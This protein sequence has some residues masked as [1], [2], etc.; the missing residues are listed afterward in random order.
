MQQSRRLF[1][2]EQRHHR[3][4][5]II[6]MNTVGETAV[7]SAGT[8]E[9]A[10]DGAVPSGPVDPGWTQYDDAAEQ[11]CGILLGGQQHSGRLT[12]RS[13]NRLLG[14]HR[15]V[16]LPQHT[17]GGDEDHPLRSPGQ[18]RAQPA[19]CVAVSPPVALS[20]RAVSGQRHHYRIGIRQ[21]LC[22]GVGQIQLQHRERQ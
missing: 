4:H 20:I 8:V 17:G 2:L 13:R 7:I 11:L 12:L 9:H 15:A 14:D 6:A 22:T 5:Q 16:V 10:L 18:R 1:R 19:E 3:A 21:C